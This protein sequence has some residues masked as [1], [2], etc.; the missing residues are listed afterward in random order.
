MCVFGSLSIYIYIYEY[1]LYTYFYDY[2]ELVYAA[3]FLKYVFLIYAYIIDVSFD[4]KTHIIDV[5]T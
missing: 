5:A 3:Y 1:F 4:S 2:D